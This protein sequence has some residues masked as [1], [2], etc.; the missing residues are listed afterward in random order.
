MRKLIIPIILIIVFTGILLN[1]ITMA[2]DS[3]I[4]YKEAIFAGGCFWCNEAA[5]EEIE[6]VKESISGYTGGDEPNPTYEEVLSGT[7]GHHEAVKI[8]YDP[9][10]I[11]YKELVERFWRQID[12][13]DTE[14]Q[15]VDKGSQY[16]TAIFYANEEEKKIAEESKSGIA[17]K[18]EKPIATKILPLKPFYEAEEYHQDYYKKRVSS[19]NAYKK[20]SGRDKLEEIW[21]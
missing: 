5:F 19:Y 9:A 18:F 17:E 6:G 3:D 12:P 7:T 16:T 2:K 21:E 14:G 8:I 10:V 1:E 20:G 13:T 11:S 15:F 4:I